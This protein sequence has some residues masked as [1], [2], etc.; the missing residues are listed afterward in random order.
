MKNLIRFED[1]CHLKLVHEYYSNIEKTTFDEMLENESAKYFY[2]SQGRQA[3]PWNIPLNFCFDMLYTSGKI[4]HNK[5]SLE[6]AQLAYGNIESKAPLMFVSLPSVHK[7]KR[8]FIPWYMMDALAS[9]ARS[10]LRSFFEF[11]DENNY[12]IDENEKEL[13]DWLKEIFAEFEEGTGI[14]ILAD[15][16]G[17]QERMFLQEYDEMSEQTREW[18]Q[19]YYD[20]QEE[21]GESSSYWWEFASWMVLDALSRLCEYPI[22]P[23][24]Y[25]YL[26]GPDFPDR[27]K[28]TCDFW[29]QNHE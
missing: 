12:T 15:I 9:L 8:A 29:S 18:I 14:K 25:Y 27:R 20:E 13:W 17:E 2:E 5:S 10:S 22:T 24:E 7:H 21:T 4:W 6:R 23:K 28:P 3:L 11:K 26:F 19:E 1:F 16:I